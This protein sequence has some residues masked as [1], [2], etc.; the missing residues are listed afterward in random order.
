MSTDLQAVFVDRDGVLNRYL[1]GDYVKSPS[2]LQILPGIPQ[3][4]ARLNDAGL[5]VVIIS[6]QQG[7]GKE[8]MTRADLDIVKQTLDT[9][10]DF[11]AGAFIDRHY[12][13]TDLKDSGSDRRKPKPGMLYEA[14]ADLGFDV[15]KTAFIGDSATDIA[16][17]RAVGAA[18]A[19]LVLTGATNAESAA[20]IWPAPDFIVPSLVEAVDLILE[21]HR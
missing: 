14:A 7:V 3:A 2:E 5:K 1:P 4:I 8:I 20:N 9:T 12:Y 10:L 11:E 16:A 6:N 17:A 18:T 19:I 21:E 13:C 15:E